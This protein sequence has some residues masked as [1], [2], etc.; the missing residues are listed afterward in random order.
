MELVRRG[1][2]TRHQANLSSSRG[3][4]FGPP[5]SQADHP[6]AN[7]YNRM[8]PRKQ[9]SGKKQR[10]LRFR[11]RTIYKLRA[12]EK[13]TNGGLIL[14]LSLSLFVSLVWIQQ[15]AEQRYSLVT[16]LVLHSRWR[17][18]KRFLQIANVHPPYAVQNSRS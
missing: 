6:V 7:V 18:V 12:R 16:G 1:N 3:Q 9:D 10:W 11:L 13:Q 5:V 17:D 2:E 14:S 4:F 8:Y 15:P